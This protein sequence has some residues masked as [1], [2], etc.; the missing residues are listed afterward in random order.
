VV[1]RHG[2]RFERGPHRLVR[3]PQDVDLVDF[4]MIDHANGPE[5]FRIAR[6][7]DIHFFAQ[8][9]RELF[10]IVQLAVPEFLRKDYRRRDNRS[11]EC[12]PTSF[13]DPGDARDADSAQFLFVA[14]AA[15]PIHCDLASERIND[16]A[17]CPAA[18]IANSLSR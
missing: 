11:G 2:Q 6:K 8:F 1:R 16:L 7:I 10:G 13:I 3:R 18:S 5:H 17:I 14:K 12:A 9:G 4:N 15:A